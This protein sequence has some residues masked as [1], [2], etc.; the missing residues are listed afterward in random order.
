MTKP[1]HRKAQIKEAFNQ[2]MSTRMDQVSEEALSPL[3]EYQA[4][5]TECTELFSTIYDQLPVDIQI[6]FT[7]YEEVV[8]LIQG[9]AESTMYEQG[10]KDG[11]QLSQMLY[12]Y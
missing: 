9:L 11:L 12:S 8:T 6:L 1:L 4:L 10:I 7:Q 3:P 5:T 2:F